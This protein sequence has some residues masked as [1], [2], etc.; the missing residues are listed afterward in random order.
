MTKSR[1]PWL[2]ALLT[3]LVPGLGHVYVGRPWVAIIV[4]VAVQIVGLSVLA[5]WVLLAPSWFTV[6]VGFLTLLGVVVTAATSAAL[7]ARSAGA[8]YTLRPYNRWYG[9]VGAVGLLGIWSWAGSAVRTSMARAFR[10]P[11]PTMEPA[12]L[13]GDFV[14]VARFPASIRIPDNGAV[15]VFRSVEPSTPDLRVVKRV[16]GS[17]G[18]TLRMVHDTVYRN[19]TRLAEPYVLRL[20]VNPTIDPE[21]LAQIRAWQQGHYVG[22]EPMTYWP[23]THDWGPIV[24]PAAHYFVLGDNRDESYDSRYYGFVPQDNIE[25]RPRFIYF[26]YGAS[27]G[28]VRWKRIGRGIE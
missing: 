8:T 17:P 21:R 14:Y 26:S 22:D 11:S 10:I 5:L 3:V 23:T 18:D 12:L 19:G 9:Y 16:I 1:R 27:A 20:G 6:V 25:G 7:I 28:G 13:V 4:A 2:A 24:V 15:V